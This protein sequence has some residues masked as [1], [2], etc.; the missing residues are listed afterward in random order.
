MSDPSIV[1]KALGENLQS[2][3]HVRNVYGEPV[4]AQGRTIIPVAKVMYG[5]GAGSG[6]ASA[7]R[8]S[9]PAGQGGGG[10]GGVRAIPVG[11]LE[12][13]QAGTRFVRLWDAK[14]AGVALG[15]A[16]L[17]GALLGRFRCRR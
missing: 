8:E 12:I 14:R 4:T 2:G 13:S 3:A 15:A 11:A 1:I 16:F 9:L 5:Y 7:G 10:G 6:G 17:F